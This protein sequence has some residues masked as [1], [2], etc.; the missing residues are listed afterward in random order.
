MGFII[1]IMG[2]IFSPSYL[3]EM[4]TDT[5]IALSEFTKILGVSLWVMFGILGSK[6]LIKDGSFI[7]FV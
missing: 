3:L 7:T 4:I 1:E 2:D 5:E 6:I